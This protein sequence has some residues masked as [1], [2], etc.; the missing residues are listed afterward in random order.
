[1]EDKDFV[2][3]IHSTIEA[4]NAGK[5]IDRILIS[6]GL[7]GEHYQDLMKLVRLYNIPF[8]QVPVERI[9]RVTR[10]NHQGVLAFIS[11]IAYQP[12]TEI[13]PMLYEQGK[14][15]LILLLDRITDVRNFGAIARSAE[16]AG[17]DA[18]LIP[19]KGAAQI[20]ADAMK[21]SSGA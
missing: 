14:N 11:P 8:Q 5:E 20:N 3:G 17:V 6:K 9:D 19:E 1:M 4:I 21:T 12:I 7:Q 13:I 2:F 15:P 18:I 10:K 16:V